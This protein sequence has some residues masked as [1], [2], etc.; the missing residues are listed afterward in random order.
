MD[1]KVGILLDWVAIFH[2][3]LMNFIILKQQKQLIFKVKTM[4]MEL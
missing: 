1:Y 4:E 2:N 3:H